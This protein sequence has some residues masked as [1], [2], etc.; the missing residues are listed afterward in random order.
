MIFVPLTACFVRAD[1]VC[2]ALRE[3]KTYKL[4]AY[5]SSINS[6]FRYIRLSV[7][8]FMAKELNHPNTI[9]WKQQKQCTNKVEKNYFYG[10]RQ[11]FPLYHL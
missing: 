5:V 4:F 8:I 6:K 7:K 11:A 9:G 1:C 3:I 10:V 2:V